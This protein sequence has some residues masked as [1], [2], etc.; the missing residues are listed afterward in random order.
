MPLSSA[1]R[2]DFLQ[3]YRMMQLIRRVEERLMAEYHPAD[4][5]RC[6]MHFCVGQESAP[7]VLSQLL[8]PGDIMMSHYRSHGYYLGKGGSLKEMI[9]EFY[10][11]ATGA[12]GGVAGSM[13]LGSHEHNFFS[14]A[15]VG[16][17]VGIPLGAAFAEKYANTDNIS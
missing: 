4:Q 7:A 17:S 3:L 10:G 13:E 1:N 6:P 15:I 5:M 11:K 16:G 12:N 2:I 9:A 8:R 14:G